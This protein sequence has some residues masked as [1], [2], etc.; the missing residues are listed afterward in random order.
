MPQITIS[1]LFALASSYLFALYIHCFYT[2]CDVH[3][4][5]WDVTEKVALCWDSET[6]WTVENY[7]YIRLCMNVGQDTELYNVIISYQWRFL[8]CLLDVPQSYRVVPGCS[9][10]FLCIRPLDLRY[11][12][13]MARQCYYGNLNKQN[14]HAYMPYFSGAILGF[15]LEFFLGQNTAKFW[16]TFWD[17]LN[18]C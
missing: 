13:V 10:D 3:K 6:M 9:A 1:H 8:F 17:I 14:I 11:T 5:S 15:F 7:M 4:L 16:D 18:E 12:L 2:T